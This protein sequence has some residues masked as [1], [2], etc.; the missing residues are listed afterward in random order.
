MDGQQTALIIGAGPAGL[1]AALEL[2][3]HTSVRPVILDEGT[4]AGGLSRTEIHGG[5][6]MDLGGHRFFSRSEAILK[7]WQNMLPLQGHPALDDVLP[8]QMRTFSP[9]GPDPEKTDRVMLERNR[10]SRIY[11]DGHFFDYPVSLRWETLLNLG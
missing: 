9:G 7:I 8:G 6:R 3:Q 10:L 11:F 1:M 2:L 4:K 5:N